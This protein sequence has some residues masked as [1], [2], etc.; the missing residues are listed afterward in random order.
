MDTP[1]F[2]SSVQQLEDMVWTLAEVKCTV[3]V[4]IANLQNLSYFYYA[5]NNVLIYRN[6]I[7]VC[8]SI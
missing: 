2:N 3:H 7:W 1:G 5:N 6:S 4:K 8:P